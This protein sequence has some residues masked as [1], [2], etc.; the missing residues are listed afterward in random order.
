[1]AWVGDLTQVGL[2]DALTTW[3][4]P[5]ASS[6]RRR[7]DARGASDLTKALSTPYRGRLLVLVATAG[8]VYLL[9]TRSGLS[10]TPDSW[11]Y[12]EGSVSLLEGCGL[13]YVGGQPITDWPPLFFWYL[14]AVQAVFGKSV[15]AL[16]L[17][18]TVLLAASVLGWAK[19]VLRTH[20]S[21]NRFSVA[22]AAY[23]ALFVIPWYG[24]LLSELLALAILPSLLLELLDIVERDEVRKV[25]AIRVLLFCTALL[26]TRHASLA[27]VPAIA[28]IPIVSGT[29]TSARFLPTAASL[30]AV[31]VWASVN[32]WLQVPTDAR[33]SSLDVASIGSRSA[34]AVLGFGWLLAT[35]RWGLD[36]L[37]VAM[38][39]TAIGLSFFSRT[40]LS[41]QWVTIRSLLLFAGI[42]FVSLVILLAVSNPADRAA[43]RF[44]LH[45][46]P[47]II[48]AVS[49]AG[50]A[51]PAAWLRR[52]V[53][54]TLLFLLGVQSAR[55]AVLVANGSWDTWGP[56]LPATG[57][58]TTYAQSDTDLVRVPDFPWVSR[59]RNTRCGSS[60]SQSMVR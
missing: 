52:L 23:I 26:L 20:G 58:L 43:G 6:P 41:V 11:A 59:D 57:R 37:A 24:V 28:F 21:W 44:L 39:A 12:W 49:A 51:G 46:V 1:M 22:S 16:T 2:A 14:A 56:V 34:E 4:G 8:A 18:C 7:D 10:F 27:L 33:A 9:S 25:Q 29:V 30:G 50:S 17:A 35:T 42:S 32:W 19:L 55:V 5:P 60:R 40:N 47:I 36:N 13:R 15:F 48:V 38:V 54:V 31:A 3:F 45:F 53:V